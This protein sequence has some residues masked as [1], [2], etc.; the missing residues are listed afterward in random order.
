M[1][2]SPLKYHGGKHYLAKPIISLMPPHLNYC[3]LFGGSLA[4]LLERDPLQDRLGPGQP[5]YQRGCSEV[6]NDLDGRLMNFWRVLQ[7]PAAFVEFQRQ[8]AAIPFSEGHW[9]RARDLSQTPVS[10]QPCV[11]AAVAFFVYARQSRA[12]TFK[13][14]ATLTKNRTRRGMSEQA[15]AWLSCIEKLPEVHA[16]LQRVVIL[17]HDALDVIRQQDGPLTLF[18]LDPPYLHETRATTGQYSYEMSDADHERLLAVL[19]GIKGK[20]MLSGYANPLY[21]AAARKFGWRCADFDL[22]NNAA[23][24]ESKRRMTE[25]LWMNF[26]DGAVHA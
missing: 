25:R 12:G 10:P 19:G 9:E 16:R 8:V 13:D 4:V 6:V 22:P 5:S 23:G 26:H 15:S 2:T 18:Y 20:F 24:G 17:N 1:V 11:D 3:E 21:D 14:F 7:D